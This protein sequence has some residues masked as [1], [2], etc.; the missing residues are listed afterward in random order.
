MVSL[1]PTG[2][3]PDFFIGKEG[4]PEYGLKDAKSR[5]P[6]KK[7]TIFVVLFVMLNLFQHL[8]FSI[9]RCRNKFGMTKAVDAIYPTD[10]RSISNPTFQIQ[11]LKS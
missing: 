10:A 5:D 9:T 7:L 11:N 2:R 4:W 8:N 3:N 1:S 6:E